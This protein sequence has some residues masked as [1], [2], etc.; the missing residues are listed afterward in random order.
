MKTNLIVAALAALIS[1]A[2]IAAP[3]LAHPGEDHS[4]PAPQTAEGQGVVKAINLR[5]KTVTLQHGP[6]AAL[7]WPAMTM[8]FRVQSADVLKGVKVGKRVHFVLK[9]ENGKPVITA[10]HLL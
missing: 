3:V 5:A 10:I 6:I 4:A 2:G 9:N 8:T 7:K 1:T